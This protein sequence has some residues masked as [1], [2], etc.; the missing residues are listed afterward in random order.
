MS[1]VPGRLITYC[2]NIHPGESWAETFAALRRHTPLVKAAVS[3]TQPFPIG[4]RLSHAAALE[5]TAEENARFVDW[6]AESDCFVPTLN[7]FPYGAFHGERVKENV[8]LPDWRSPERA[9]Y[10]LRLAE[11]LA[12]WLPEGVTGSISTVPLGFKGVV[13]DADLPAMRRQLLVVLTHLRRIQDELGRD[14]VLALEPEPGCLLETTDEVCHFFAQLDLPAD[15]ADRLGVCYDCCHQAVEFESPADSLAKL[16]EAEVRIAK[17]QVSSA[18]R[19]EPPTAE[20]IARFDEPRYLHQVVVRN[21]DGA[22]FRYPDLPVARAARPVFTGEEWRCH[23]HVPIFLD[24]AGDCAT[25]RPFL[26]E[27]LP[28]L[29]PDLLLEVETYTWDVLPPELRTATV[30]DSIIR[31]MLWLEA[32]LLA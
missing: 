3:P 31:E 11:R 12:G 6:L 1:E 19:L 27:I 25:T 5:L 10:S 22:L 13:G 32:E 9:A 26:E 23:F 20:L 30:T 2:S 8:Y 28:L 29:P 14:I 24:R 4:L 17:V 16:R 21:P 15:L 18:L 7:G